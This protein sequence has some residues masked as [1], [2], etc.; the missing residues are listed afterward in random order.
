MH[1]TITIDPVTRL[2]GHLKVEVDVDGSKQVTAARSSGTLFRGFEKILIGRDPR[3]ATHITQRICGVCPVSHGMASTLCL[4]DA[5]GVTPAENGRIMRNL[6]LAANFVQS[7]ILHFYHLAALDFVK[8]PG[9]PPWTPF[10]DDEKPYTD[11]AAFYRFDDATT[12]VIVSHYVQALQ[13]RMKA[14]EMGAIFGGKLPHVPSF[15]AGGITESP[16]DEDISL[17]RSYLDVL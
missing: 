5:F 4:E 16:T 1:T 8:G 9:I 14:Q 2:E 13:M 10:Y 11:P 17:F 6:V 7:H 15:V 12:E 3:D